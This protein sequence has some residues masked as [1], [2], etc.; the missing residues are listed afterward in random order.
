MTQPPIRHSRTA[1]SLVELLVVIALITVL[2]ILSGMGVGMVRGKSQA[3]SCMH[4]MRQ[5]V[6]GVI[7]YNQDYRGYYPPHL[8]SY[9]TQEGYRTLVWYGHIATYVAGWDQSANSPMGRVFY[10]PANKLADP[11]SATTYISTADATAA[12]NYSYGFNYAKLSS[13]AGYANVKSTAIG[14]KSSLVIL[15]EIKDF[16]SPEDGT[17]FSLAGVAYQTNLKQY[18]GDR[19]LSTR[20]GGSSNFA[21][22]DG[23]IES[24]PTKEFINTQFDIRNWVPETE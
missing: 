13:M 9:S 8:G 21:F 22:A 19:N 5:L 10:C 4:N 16:Q 1:F 20:H 11:N 7:L 3:T 14:N 6:M 2:I 24:R 15:S 23:H 17:P 12:R 18:P